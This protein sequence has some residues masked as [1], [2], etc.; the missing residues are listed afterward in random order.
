MFFCENNMHH[1][2]CYQ[3]F[4]QKVISIQWCNYSSTLWSQTYMLFA[5]SSQSSGGVERGYKQRPKRTA[6]YLLCHHVITLDKTW[7]SRS[8]IDAF[9]SRLTLHETSDLLLTETKCI[10]FCFMRLLAVVAECGQSPLS[11]SNCSN[12]HAL[13]SKRKFQCY[14]QL[15][16]SIY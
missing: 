10:C 3:R 14:L 2:V 4:Y 7:S 12:H 6:K 16:L 13:Q 15:W 9:D 8:T 5:S 1:S 11:R